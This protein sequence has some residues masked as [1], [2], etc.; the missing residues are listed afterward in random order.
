MS[1]RETLFLRI[2]VFGMESVSGEIGDI[3][4]ESPTEVFGDLFNSKLEV[5]ILGLVE[6]GI[7]GGD[8]ASELIGEI[9]G[10]TDNVLDKIFEDESPGTESGPEFGINGGDRYSGLSGVAI[11]GLDELSGSKGFV[12]SDPK[13]ES[14]PVTDGKISRTE[15]EVGELPTPIWF[16]ISKSDFPDEFGAS[17]GI[18]VSTELSADIKEAEFGKMSFEDGLEESGSTLTFVF[19]LNNDELEGCSRDPGIT[20]FGELSFETL[21]RVGD[22]SSALEGLECPIVESDVKEFSG[23][24]GRSTG[25]IWKVSSVGLSG[26]CGET[27]GKI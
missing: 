13:T 27:T 16:E 12:G 10:P 4:N 18:F 9:F 15:E 3:G 2:S 6:S 19:V 26:N 14:S 24:C 20:E 17:A 22:I 21:T 11:D 25:K 1:G 8:N 7:R 5:E 23:D